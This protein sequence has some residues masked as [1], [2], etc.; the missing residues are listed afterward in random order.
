MPSPLSVFGWLKRDRLGKAAEY[1][2]TEAEY[3]QVRKAVAGFEEWLKGKIAPQSVHRELPLLVLDGDESVVSGVM[4]LVAETAGGVWILDH[5]TDA[6]EDLG[7]AFAQY[8][9]QLE[10]YA[11]AVRKAMPG[12]KVLGLNWVKYGKVTVEDMEC[13]YQ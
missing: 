9:G 1:V 10:A 12:R 4:D 6:S 5:K 7:A 2:F 3:D 8:L 13:Q 11:D